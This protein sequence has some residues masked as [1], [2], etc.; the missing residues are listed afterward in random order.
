M[1]K[2]WIRIISLMALGLGLLVFILVQ[3]KWLSFGKASAPEKTANKPIEDRRPPVRGMIIKKA[4]LQNRIKVTGTLLP[5]EEVSVTSEVAGRVVRINFAEGQQVSQG[6]LL[7]K[8]N[9][10]EL[11]AQL[12]R[13]KAQVQL[14]ENREFRQR[15]LLEKGGVS[16]DE[17]EGIV[18]ELNAF[19]AQVKETQAQ[20]QR[21]EIRAPFAGTVG[22]RQVSNGSYINPG[23]SVVQLVNQQRLKI[24]FS[25]PEKYANA[26]RAGQKI[27]VSGESLPEP[28]PA[29]IYAIEPKINLETRT[30]TVRAYLNN[31]NNRLVP[32]AFVDIAIILEEVENAIEVPT[33]AVIPELGG[34]K[35]FVY[36]AGKAIYTVVKTGLRGEQTVQITEGLL[37][38]DTLITSGI[39]NVR[40]NVEVNLLTVE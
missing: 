10:A 28:L 16:Q 15:K 12:E 30:L 17:Y 24:E 21:T 3:A 20:I 31:P 23:T 35:V 36:K 8:I 27:L 40:P 5:D 33:V 11:R 32:G 4:V 25:V 19:Q 18:A 37:P 26:V 2:H 34:Q 39:L 9:D 7:V 1:K 14:Y 29:Q 6:T 22:L 13:L 38:G